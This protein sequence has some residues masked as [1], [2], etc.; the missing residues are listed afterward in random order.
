MILYYI[1]SC[2]PTSWMSPEN[3]QKEV[4][5]GNPDHHVQT[6]LTGVDVWTGPLVRLYFQENYEQYNIF[7]IVVAQLPF[8][9][10]RLKFP[11]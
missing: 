6:T 2:S 1:S 9:T 8:Y 11:H 4:A 7:V 10:L 3:L 5:T